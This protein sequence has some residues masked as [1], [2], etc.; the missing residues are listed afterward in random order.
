MVQPQVSMSDLVGS[1]RKA[2]PALR[3]GW[4]MGK[5]EVRGGWEKGREKWDWYVK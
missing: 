1:P 4:E 5:G 2:L 3:N